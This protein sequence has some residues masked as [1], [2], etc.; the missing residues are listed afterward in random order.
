MLPC[1]SRIIKLEKTVKFNFT[2]A[3]FGICGNRSQNGWNVLTSTANG[4]SYQP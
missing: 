2:G 4:Y 3:G 1:T